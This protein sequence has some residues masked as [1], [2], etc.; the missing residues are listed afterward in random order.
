MM[1]ILPSL[2]C[3][4]IVL[5]DIWNGKTYFIYLIERWR[6][7][8]PHCIPSPPW[9]PRQPKWHWIKEEFGFVTTTSWWPLW[10]D[11]LM[12]VVRMLIK[13]RRV[14]MTMMVVVKI[15]MFK[16]QPQSSPVER[17]P[18]PRGTRSH[19]DQKG[20]ST[21]I[22]MMQMMVTRKTWLRL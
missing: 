3:T 5:V 7:Q 15:K 6:H 13:I 21:V 2:H 16:S 10:K 18:I 1:K 17:R 22:I 9:W 4:V 8:F 12:M 11:N 19:P 14:T 20:Y